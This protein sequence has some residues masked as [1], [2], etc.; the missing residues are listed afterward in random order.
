MGLR[1]FPLRAPGDGPGAA[2]RHRHA[3]CYSGA[4]SGCAT[5]TT[6]GSV[7]VSFTGGSYRSG[8]VTFCVNQVTGTNVSFNNTSNCKSH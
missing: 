1:G 6:G 3:G 2:L 5:G 8:S 7:S 4:T